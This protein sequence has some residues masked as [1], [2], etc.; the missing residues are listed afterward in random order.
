MNL[1]VFMEKNQLKDKKKLNNEGEEEVEEEKSY[2]CIA[3]IDLEKKNEYEAL[4]NDSDTFE[5]I[6]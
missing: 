5:L 1:S 2:Y 3:E 4:F 6:V